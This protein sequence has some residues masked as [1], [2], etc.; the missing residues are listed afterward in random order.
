MQTR[1]RV[2]IKRI[3]PERR[4]TYQ[5]LKL[6]EQVLA[7]LDGRVRVD[8]YV[9]LGRT[10]LFLPCDFYLNDKIQSSKNTASDSVSNI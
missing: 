5:I 8:E 9:V 4:V 3:L 10:V 7:V 6:E 1:R 2:D